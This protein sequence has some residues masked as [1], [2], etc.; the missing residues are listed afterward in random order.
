MGGREELLVVWPGSQTYRPVACRLHSDDEMAWND[1]SD[2]AVRQAAGHPGT[3]VAQRDGHGGLQGKGVDPDDHVESIGHL[4]RHDGLL[5][6]DEHRLG[7]F[8]RGVR[9]RWEGEAELVAGIDGVRVRVVLLEESP[10]SSDGG[11]TARAECQGPLA[12]PQACTSTAIY[13]SSRTRVHARA[14]S[15]TRAHIH[16][17]NAKFS[18]AAITH[19]QPRRAQVV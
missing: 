12:A 8:P 13:R 5:R 14:R 19:T 4:G 17:L 2:E 15:R 10:E 7:W 3:V 18:C 1:R 11:A 16:W 6:R 9:A